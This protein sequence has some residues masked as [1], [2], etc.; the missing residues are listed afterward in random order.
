MS[1]FEMHMKNSC[2]RVIVAGVTSFSF[3]SGRCLVVFFKLV[4]LSIRH[5]RFAQ[6]FFFFQGHQTLAYL[7]TFYIAHSLV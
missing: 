7:S 6:C 5:C 2:T 4:A 3:L 1:D